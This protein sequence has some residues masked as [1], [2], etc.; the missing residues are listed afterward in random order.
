MMERMQIVE[1][2]HLGIVARHDEFGWFIGSCGDRAND[3]KHAEQ[4]REYRL[5]KRLESVTDSF[6]DAATHWQMHGLL[7]RH[8]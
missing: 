2:L 8:L 6:C 3:A 5:P 1:E 4:F 7:A